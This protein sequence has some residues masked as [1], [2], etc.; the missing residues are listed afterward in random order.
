MGVGG[1]GVS[2]SVD[3]T[4][5]GVSVGGTGVGV[6][7]GNPGVGVSVGRTGVIVVAGAAQPAK[8]RMIKIDQ[9]DYLTTLLSCMMNPP[10]II[11]SIRN[12]L[13]SKTQIP[14]RTPGYRQ[15]RLTMLRYRT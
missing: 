9:I 14:A 2:V 7:V 10:F 8:N 4:G 1:I 13:S 11:S 12:S 15:L 3:R 5:M 6:S